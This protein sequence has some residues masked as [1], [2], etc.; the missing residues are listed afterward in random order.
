[1]K[2]I[3][4]LAGV[5]NIVI[6]EAP[7]PTIGP[8]EV[9]IRNVRTLIS[10]GSEIGRR[11]RRSEA[12]DPAIMGYSAAG[13]V[14]EVGAAVSEL[15]VG[16]RVSAVAPHAEYVVGDLDHEDGSWVMA[17]PA[18]VGFEAATFLPLA[19]GGVTWAAIAKPEPSET[20]VILGQGLVGSLVMQAMRAAYRP[21]RLIVVDALPNRRVLAA[22]LGAEL[23][24]DAAAGDPVAAVLAATDGQGAHL[25]VDCVGG[26]AGVRS[27]AQAQ[28]MCRPFGRIHLIALYHEA[29]LPLDSSKIQ[30]RLLIGGYFT[31][32]P[33]RAFA[34]LALASIADGRLPVERLISHR[35]PY[36]Q[37]KAAFDLLHARPGEALGVLLTW[38]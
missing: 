35:F 21:A 17:L 9:L 36:Q 19:T 29:T 12:I 20:V 34:E 4:K 32:E 7:R 3:G 8:R 11:Y 15:V 18:T 2:R 28:E 33:R 10:R 6:E 25:V 31:Q 23:V 5:G 22:E 16:Q 14:V 24:I 27:F 38:E 26:P 30:Q 1:M 37:A 13:V